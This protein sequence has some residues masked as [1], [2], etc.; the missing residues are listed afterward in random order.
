M[1]KVNLHFVLS[2]DVEEEYADELGKDIC[3]DIF[4]ELFNGEDYL[5]VFYDK[6]TVV[7]ED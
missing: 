5:N 3:H 2:V 6:Y 1:S 4:H 7:E